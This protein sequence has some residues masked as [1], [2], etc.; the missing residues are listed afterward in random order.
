[1]KASAHNLIVLLLSASTWRHCGNIVK[2]NKEMLFSK[3]TFDLIEHYCK[4]LSSLQKQNVK[5]PIYTE[6]E[7]LSDFLKLC[8]DEGISKTVMLFYSYKKTSIPEAF[9]K[10]YQRTH[11]VSEIIESLLIRP[12]LETI[13]TILQNTELITSPEFISI[14]S[15]INSQAR[16]K[17]FDGSSSI[18]EKLTTELLTYSKQYIRTTT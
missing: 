15:D 3:E 18:V 1:M 12:K 9:L 7:T 4:T 16:S 13:T 5:L 8:K 17:A 2:E 10:N 6:L 11:Q 14:C